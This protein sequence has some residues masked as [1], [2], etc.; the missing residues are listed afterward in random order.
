MSQAVR[1]E[2]GEL[3]RSDQLEQAAEL[4]E[5]HGLFADAARL[6]ERACH[7]DRAARTALRAE[8]FSDALLLSAQAREARLLDESVRALSA[9]PGAARQAAERAARAGHRAAAAM[10]YLAIGDA[11]AAALELEQSELWL[12]AARAHER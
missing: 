1:A 12:E 9:E 11:S 10:V 2:L 8:H 3:E 6:W 7:F 4:A 5:L